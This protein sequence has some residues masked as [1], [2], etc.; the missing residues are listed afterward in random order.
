MEAKLAE[1][2]ATRDDITTAHNCG[3]GYVVSNMGVD[4]EEEAAFQVELRGIVDKMKEDL[5]NETRILEGTLEPVYQNELSD[6]ECKDE[7]WKTDLPSGFSTIAH[8]HISNTES[9][10][11][12]SFAERLTQTKDIRN[13]DAQSFRLSNACFRVMSDDSGLATEPLSELSD[14]M[15]Q[16]I[17][18]PMLGT[19][20]EEK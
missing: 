14:C 8:T 11:S 3:A 7:Q 10:T 17:N 1:L 20:S 2:R 19:L 18:V 9:N 4:I 12:S 13:F 16:T 6:S 15:E 5:V